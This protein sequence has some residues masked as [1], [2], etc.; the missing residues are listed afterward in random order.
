M[1]LLSVAT[2]LVVGAA[3]SPASRIGQVPGCRPLRWVGVR[4][5]G[6]Y[7][8]H[9]PIIVVTASADGRESLARGALQVAASVG[10][11]ALSWRFVEEPVRHGAIG[12]WRARV[13]VGQWHL[14]AAGGQPGWPWP[15]Q[16]PWPCWQPPV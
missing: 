3:A 2:V 1:A 10:A 15:G 7:L 13:T 14:R 12:R 9:Y 11:A 4:S 5:H 8:W 6:T 16:P